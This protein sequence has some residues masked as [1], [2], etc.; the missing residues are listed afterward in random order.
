MSDQ[1][2]HRKYLNLI[3]A[4]KRLFIIVALL[5]I[6]VVVITS[7]ILPKKYE[8]SSTIF[9]EKNVINDLVKGIAVTPSMDEAIKVLRYS[10]TSRTIISKVISDLDLD[11]GAKSAIDKEQLIRNMQKNIDVKVKDN[12]LFIISFTNRNARTARDF[13]NTIVQRYI[14]ESISSKR[15]ESY[16]AIKFLSEQMDT[17]RGKLEVAETELNKF[18]AEKGGVINI[19]EAKLFEDINAAKQKLY[20]IQ[21]RR[22]YLEGMKPVTRKAGD[23]LQSK[24]SALEKR[25]DELRVEYT[26]K[27]PDVVKTKSDIETLKAQMKNRKAEGETVAEPQ[28]LGKVEAELNALKISEQGLSRYIS[29]NE[30]LLNSIPTA[31]AGLEKLEL[32]KNNRK[33]LYDKLMARHGQSEVSKQ[34]EVQDK[35]TTFRIVD[36]AVMPIMPVSPNRVKIILMGI[37]AGLAC[38]LGLLVVLDHLDTSIKTVD[39]LKPLG[40]Q[41]IAVV[42]KISNP[43]AAAVERVKDFRLYTVAGGYFALILALLVTEALRLSLVDKAIVMIRGLL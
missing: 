31:K 17:V 36:P 16:G 42:P 10:I 9:I 25:L 13:V 11:T 40:V 19:D 3:I 22:R 6:T 1:F 35:T 37:F 4:R 26:D 29:T 30:S 41:L 15:E 33:E 2:D 8:A 12:N 39:A 5:V 43:A 21:L 28:E 32:E 20:D 24:L 7:Y 27:Y 18:R 14:E 34:M 23:P 38:G